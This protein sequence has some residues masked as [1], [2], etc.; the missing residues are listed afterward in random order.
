MKVVPGF[1]GYQGLSTRALKS[2]AGGTGFPASD[3]S[4]NP[5]A[6]SAFIEPPRFCGPRYEPEMNPG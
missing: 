6:S 5:T 2:D 3:I 1:S 4:A